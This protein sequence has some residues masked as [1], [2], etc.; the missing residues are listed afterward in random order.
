MQKLAG[1]GITIEPWDYRYYAE[2][3]RKERYDLDENEVKPYLQ[4][5]KLREGMFEVAD[6]LF[7]LRFTPVKGL[8]VYHPDVRVWEVKDATGKHVGLWY[9]DPYA[10][11]GKQSGAWMSQYRNQERFEREITTIVSN[12]S[13]FVKGKPGEPVLV[14]WTDAETLFH[15][16]GHALHGLRSNVTYPTL[17]GTN[18]PNDYVEFPSQILERWLETPEILSRHA[19]HFRTGKPMPKALLEK[20]QRASRFNQGFATLE[21]LSSALV[22]MKAHLATGP[23]EPAAFEKETLA[24]LG[25]PRELVMRH[26]LPQFNHFFTSDGYSAGYYSYLWADTLSA[27]AYEAFTEAKGPW[28]R[29]VA[30]RLK[31][32]VFSAGNTVDPDEGYRAFRGKDP[33]IAALMR[34]RGFPVPAAAAATAAPVPAPASAPVPVTA[35]APAPKPTKP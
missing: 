4:L 26:R 32:H 33:G 12:N 20:L 16:F 18:V 3:V 11:P 17:S 8:P 1:T 27:D 30:A 14:S 15:E 22:D 28:D 25:M 34:K 13:N 5:E 23:V 7:G 24:A 29:A 35:P 9:F 2:K 21:Y 31:Q 19:V 10:R 6:R